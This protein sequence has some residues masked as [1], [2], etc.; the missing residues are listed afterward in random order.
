MGETPKDYVVIGQILKPRGTRGKVDVLSLSDFPERFKPG[1]RVFLV[2]P[3]PGK[4]ELVVSEASSQPKGLVL[5]FKGLD[6]RN[7][8]EPLRE[9]YIAV[10]RNEVAELPAGS[11]WVDEIVG[12]EVV[13]VDGRRI[14]RVK[15]VLRGSGQDVYVVEGGRGKQHLIPAVREIVKEIDVAG[16][17][18]IIKPIPGL[19]E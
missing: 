10:P 13:S 14:G 11:Y 9:R 3:L 18:I 17:K 5:A 15:E 1:L 4:R 12:L 6:T 8:V 16:G 2:P 7:D 19:L